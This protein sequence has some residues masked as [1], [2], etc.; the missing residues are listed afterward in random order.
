MS[1]IPETGFLRANQIHGCR[2]KGI[3]AILPIS[4]SMWWQGIADGRFPTGIKIAPR[5]TVWRAE[6]IRELLECMSRG[7]FFTP[8]PKAESND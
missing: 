5:T 1:Q 8:S 3:P 7:E 6:D 2:R 4:R